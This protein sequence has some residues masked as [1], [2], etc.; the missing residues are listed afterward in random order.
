MSRPQ[1][2]EPGRLLEEALRSALR[3]CGTYISA[4]ENHEKQGPGCLAPE[5]EAL[6]KSLLVVIRASGE[7]IV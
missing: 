5:W 4:S 3:N 6:R 7:F 1:I 2:D